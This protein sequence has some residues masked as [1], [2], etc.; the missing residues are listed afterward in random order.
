MKN[1]ENEML[2][3]TDENIRKF[4]DGEILGQKDAFSESVQVRL[5][6]S[7]SAIMY[8]LRNEKEYISNC[9]ITFEYN[10]SM[11]SACI[12]KLQRTKPGDWDDP[13]DLASNLIVAIF[14]MIYEKAIVTGNWESSYEFPIIDFILGPGISQTELERRQFP[15]WAFSFQKDLNK[16]EAKK[17]LL[18]LQATIARIDALNKEHNMKTKEWKKTIEDWDERL[19]EYQ[20]SLSNM[21]GQYNFV[22]LAKAF[23]ELIEKK[24]RESFLARLYLIAMAV[25]ILLPLAASIYV[26][27]LIWADANAGMDP[28]KNKLLLGLPVLI[29]LE[30]VLIYFFRI[31]LKEQLSLKAQI[32]QLEL[33]YSVCAFIEGYAKFAEGMAKD[34]LDR[35]ETL[36]FSGITPDPTAVPSTFDGM[37][38]LAGLIQ[39][40]QK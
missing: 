1:K 25:I 24:K 3:S 39:K 29:P 28:M 40:F 7:K 13:E 12:E 20:E 10:T 34:K 31:I 21:A 19:K 38:Q 30:I 27:Y 37:E 5:R 4:A 35:F 14:Q 16:S 17:N 32:L 2:I 33:R 9:A 36:I 11:I 18:E 22:G 8:I 6:L 26:S 15:L 23:K